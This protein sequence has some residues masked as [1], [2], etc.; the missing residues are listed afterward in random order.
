[1][2]R[3][4]YVD[5]DRLR[6][7][8]LGGLFFASGLLFLL[9]WVLGWSG[10]LPLNPRLDAGLP[11]GVAAAVLLGLL[12]LAQ[13]MRGAE[14]ANRT[15]VWYAATTM[16]VGIIAASWLFFG[17][18]SPDSAALFPGTVSLAALI[19]LSTLRLD[20]R[21]AAFTGVLAAACDVFLRST[22]QSLPLVSEGRLGPGATA[23]L[24]LLLGGLSAVVA[25]L[26]R[27]RMLYAIEAVAVRRRLEREITE[28]ADAER[29]RLGQDIHD[30]LGGRLSGL[31]LIA[32]G[33]AKRIE[34]GGTV[35]AGEL[36]ELA[37][38]AREGVE[39]TRRVARG[40]D[41]APVD[42]GLVEAL[43]GLAD[44]TAAAGLACSF[45]LE[46]SEVPADR[47]VTQHLYH[48][49]QEAVTNGIRH[50]APSRVD[51]RLTVRPRT[52]AL[53]VRDDGSG[54]PSNPVEGLG[55]RTMRQRAALL[56]AVLRVRAGPEGGTVVS[57]VVP[58]RAQ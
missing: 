51:L 9:R 58:R 1:M 50:G 35:E 53:D 11:I 54:L 56:G 6:T 39:E 43:R 8:V 28:V 48:I 45:E 31:A 29:S 7:A 40:L 41:P 25:E 2:I 14:A 52:I 57:C 36:R 19:V 15:L 21:L 49:A 33:L 16:E 22:F 18:R 10:I 12:Q 13:R 47:D 46:G 4:E 44:R 34:N 3:A 20:W 37:S 26:G 27:R 24:L 5:A 17:S 23:G 55:L 42:V 38:L 30:G 32:Q